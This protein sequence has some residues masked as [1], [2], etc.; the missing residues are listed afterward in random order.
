MQHE[1]APNYK[2]HRFPVE[3][4]SPAVWLYQNVQDYPGLIHGAPQVM[5]LAIDLHKDFIEVPFVARPGATL[6]LAPAQVKKL[7]GARPQAAFVDKGFRGERYHP[8]AVA[9]YLAGRRNLSARSAAAHGRE[10]EGPQE[11]GGKPAG[12]GTPLG[13]GGPRGDRWKL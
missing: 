10:K 9:V 12:P 13:W 5:R 2:N 4:I 6:K 7:T 11:K 8:T 3:I 1:V